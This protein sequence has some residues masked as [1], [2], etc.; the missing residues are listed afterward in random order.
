MIQGGFQKPHLSTPLYSG[1]LLSNIAILDL[2]WI[3]A[4]GT[5]SQ[6]YCR[7]PLLKLMQFLLIPPI[8]LCHFSDWA[9]WHSIIHL[10]FINL[11]KKVIFPGESRRLKAYKNTPNKYKLTRN[12]YKTKIKNY[13]HSK[14]LI[15]EERKAM[16]ELKLHTETGKEFHKN[17]IFTKKENLY[18]WIAGRKFSHKHFRMRSSDGRIKHK[19][20]IKGNCST[21]MNQVIQK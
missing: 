15:T 6:Y 2:P 20:I 9:S 4:S 18:A 5:L 12:T 7:F 14:W 3:Q 17:T 13:I 19:I 11:W 8:K 10:F 16:R 21:V 1:Q